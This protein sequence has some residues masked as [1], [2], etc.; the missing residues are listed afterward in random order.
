MR[1]KMGQVEV[2]KRDPF[3]PTSYMKLRERLQR[4]RGEGKIS[5]KKKQANGERKS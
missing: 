4:G 5:K 1:S 2:K 3:W